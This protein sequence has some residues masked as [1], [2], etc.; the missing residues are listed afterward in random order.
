MNFK[1][2]L[3]SK[4]DIESAIFTGLL[5]DNIVYSVQYE[6]NKKETTTITVNDISVFITSKKHVSMTHKGKNIKL[7]HT[8]LPSLVDKIV[9]EFNLA[10]YGSSAFG[11][12]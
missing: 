2:F 4:K 11:N 12:F 8:D 3:L 7:T 9:D 1:S 5:N 6:R 10:G